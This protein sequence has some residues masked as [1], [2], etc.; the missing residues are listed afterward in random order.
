MHFLI[1]IVPGACLLVLLLKEEHNTVHFLQN[2]WVL[3]IIKSKDGTKKDWYV[4][5]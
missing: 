1:K 2:K 5:A 4:F 3:Q